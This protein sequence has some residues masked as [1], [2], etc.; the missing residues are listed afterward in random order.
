[1]SYSHFI[2]VHS[3]GD[4][5]TL[6]VANISSYYVYN[7]MVHV[8]MVSSE[9]WIINESYDELRQLI[10]DAG[11]IVKK[12]DPRLDDK[13]MEWDD[14]A[15]QEGEIFY[16]SNACDWRKFIRVVELDNGTTWLEFKNFDGIF[17][18]VYPDDLK[19]KPM[20]RMKV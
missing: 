18:S 15:G 8:I 10:F 20:Y 17:Q 7:N 19:A 13:Q 4:R 11:C 5:L 6:N 9:D 3:S 14:F 1:M 2:E 12:A 16:D